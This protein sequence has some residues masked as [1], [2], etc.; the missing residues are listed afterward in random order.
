MFLSQPSVGTGLEAIIVSRT[1]T[2]QINEMQNILI[3][4]KLNWRDVAVERSED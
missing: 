2:K 1:K 3:I 4:R